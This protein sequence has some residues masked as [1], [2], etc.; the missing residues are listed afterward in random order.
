M[1][2]RFGW[3]AGVTEP[4]RRERGAAVMS[5]TVAYNQHRILPPKGPSVPA[6]TGKVDGEEVLAESVVEGRAATVGSGWGGAVGS[7]R[8]RR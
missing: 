5:R 8:E 3:G 4:V 2:A 1:L 6:R 7:L